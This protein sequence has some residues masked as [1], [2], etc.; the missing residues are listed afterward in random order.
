MKKK[1]KVGGVTL[2]EF[3]TSYKATVNRSV[4]HWQKKKK[5]IAFQ[6]AI[7]PA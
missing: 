4:G 7:F 6:D 1:N 2:P 5:G 3:K